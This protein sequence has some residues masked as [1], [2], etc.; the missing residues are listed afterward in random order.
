MG[1]THGSLITT[2]LN[3]PPK[4]IFWKQMPMREDGNGCYFISPC[5]FALMQNEGCAVN[6]CPVNVS[7]I[8]NRLIDRLMTFTAELQS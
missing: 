8:R 2:Y 3:L 7:K 6:K 4:A 1:G 5:S